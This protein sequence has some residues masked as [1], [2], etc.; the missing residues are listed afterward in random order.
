MT[1][2]KPSWQDFRSALSKRKQ[3]DERWRDF[4]AKRIADRADKRAPL[5]TV[6]MWEPRANPDKVNDR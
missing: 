5:E 3:P 1:G 4:M 2:D 6:G